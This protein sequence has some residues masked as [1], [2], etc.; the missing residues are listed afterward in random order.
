M[1]EYIEGRLG[2]LFDVMMMMMME[3][4]R[5]EGVRNGGVGGCVWVRYI[6]AGRG[7]AGRWGVLGHEIKVNNYQ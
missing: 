6:L 7:Y 3:R 4:M 2:R 5:R 1:G